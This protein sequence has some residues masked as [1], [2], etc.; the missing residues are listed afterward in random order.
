MQSQIRRWNT[1]HAAE[2]ETA[3]FNGSGMMI[4]ENIFGS[5]DPWPSQDRAT[6]RRASVI[7]RHFASDFRS[8][9]WEPFYPILFD[10]FYAKWAGKR[11]PTEAEWQL[12]A[13]G[14][15]GRAWPW[16]DEFDAT[17]CNASGRGTMPVRSLPDGRS[18]CGCYHMSATSGNGPRAPAMTATHVSS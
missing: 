12:A 11:L 15:D 4:W 1:D 18:P 17:R 5:Y 7:L 16:G 14:T 6:W 13:Q 9:R 10:G 2:I 8:E 3:F